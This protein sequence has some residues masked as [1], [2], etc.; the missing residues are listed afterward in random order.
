MLGVPSVH[1]LRESRPVRGLLAAGGYARA[2]RMG[3]RRYLAAREA[4]LHLLPSW[5][6]LHGG[7]FVDVGANAGDWTDAVLR[8]VPGATAICAEPGPEPLAQLAERFGGR[9][10]VTIDARAV[11]DA[12]GTA[13][14]HRTRASVFAS[15][16]PPAEDLT[17]RY[18]LLGGPAELIDTVEVPTVTLDELVGGDRVSVLKLDVQGAELSVLRGGARTLASTEAILAEVLF[19]PHYVGDAT[20][21]PLHEALAAHGFELVDMGGR[22]GSARAR[23]CGLTL[24]TYAGAKVPRRWR[25][26]TMT[27]PTPRSTT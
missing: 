7:R 21:G 10:E 23:R 6:P 15:L 14:L 17:A 19:V 3:P 26:I 24:G 20:F 18:D 1:Q 16:L 9:P 11:S 13:T 12:T 4:M 5:V 8:A 22:S 2:H 25:R 27:A